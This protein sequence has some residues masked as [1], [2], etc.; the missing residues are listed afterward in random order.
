MSSASVLASLAER[1]IARNARRGSDSRVRLAYC[2][3]EGFIARRQAFG[4]DAL[5]E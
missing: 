5:S 1:P 3:Q 4:V 2:A